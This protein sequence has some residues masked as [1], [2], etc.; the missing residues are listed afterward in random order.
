LR[1]ATLEMG[2]PRRDYATAAYRTCP[3]KAQCT[4]NNGG[5]RITRWVDEP[6]LEQMAQRVHAH[7]A[8]MKQRKAL[9][10]PPLGTMKRGWHQGS[11][12]RRGVAKVRA[13]FRLTV[14]A[15]HLRRVWNLVAMPRLLTSLG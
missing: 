9:E 6:R 11:F 4:R 13:E 2:R 3:L 5:R 7:P 8:T 10:E 12:L 1:F 14:L 15:Y